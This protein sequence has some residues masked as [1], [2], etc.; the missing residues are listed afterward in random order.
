MHVSPFGL[1][2]AVNAP[3]YPPP[4]RHERTN[5]G[6]GRLPNSL[7]YEHDRQRFLAAYLTRGEEKSFTIATPP[8]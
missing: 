6:T 7:G 1:G 2:N 5:E 3:S 4:R 8:M